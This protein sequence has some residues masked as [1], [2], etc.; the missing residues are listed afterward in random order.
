MP[1]Q[2]IPSF[3]AGELSPRLESRPDL[4]KYASACRTLEN[5]VIM[6]YGGVNR[7]P[8]FQYIGAARYADKKCRLIGFNFSTTTNFIL[9][10][11]D[12]YVRFWSNG[13]QVESAPGVPLNVASPYLEAQLQDVQYVQINDVMYLAHPS[14]PVQKLSRISDTNWTLAPV[15][16]DYPAFRDE[17]VTS[18]TITPSATTGAVTLTASASVFDPGDVG[19]YY[20]VVHKRTTAYVERAISSTG[21]SGSLRVIGPWDFR[22]YGTWTATLNIQR[23]YG[24]GPWETIRTFR[25][26]S[27]RNISSSGDE[28]TECELRINVT[29]WSVGAATTRAYIEAQDSGVYGVVKVTGYTSPTVVTGTVIKDMFAATATE[30]WSEG[31]WSPRRGF[32]RTVAMHE[33]R[34]FFGGNTAEP[35]TIW[36]SRINDF[37]TF[38]SGTYDDSALAFTIA[39]SESNA[40]NWMVSQQVLCVGTAGYEYIVSANSADAAITP[41]SIHIRPQSHFGSKYS[42]ALLANEVTLFIQ[43]QGRKVR[44][45][46]FQFEKDGYVS[47]DLTLLA[48]H[49]TSGGIT[50][51][52]FQSQPDAILW[53][54]TGDGILAGMTYERGQNVVG[55]HRHTTDG[56]FESVATIYGQG[57][58]GD[59]VWC[60]IRRT[61]NGVTA[62]YI[63]R[64]DPAYREALEAETKASWF[65]VDS[66][67]TFT[68]VSTTTPVNGLIHLIGKTVSILADGAVVPPQTVSAL[69]QI[70]LPYPASVV[71]VGLPYTSTLKPMPLDPG[72]LPDGSAQGRKFRVN[73]MV[74]RIY[75]SLGG[76]V[77]VEEGAWDPIYSRDTADIMGSSP[78]V[79]TGDKTVMVARPYEDKGTIQIRQTQPLPLTILALIPKYDVI[80]D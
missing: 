41:S 47:A 42:R 23:R 32:P 65:Y 20:Q 31:S 50:Q 26:T 30:F 77:E 46:V 75:K 18:T 69:G 74:V 33:Q 79:F 67:K 4:E 7:R 63:E 21:V 72:Q 3:N 1:V 62:R 54:V 43:R 8:G 55:W 53:V 36:G 78:P 61:V 27:D 59:E 68:S 57:T 37:E 49:V 80:G 71:T 15:A 34:L 13:V 28:A 39:S 48:D 40:I 76:E 29:D 56:V 9:E 60:S 35:Q 73:R 12:L 19:G 44:E 70:T 10:L 22:T 6:P 38:R 45:F 24:S 17:N 25:G 5:F 52:A 66:G 16:W 11:G 51:I 14:H 58:G 2:L 64:M